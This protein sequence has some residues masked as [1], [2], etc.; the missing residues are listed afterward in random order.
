MCPLARTAHEGGAT[1]PNTNKDVKLDELSKYF[2]LPEKIVAKELGIC[3]T[4]LKKLCRS[5]GITRW[6]FRKLKSLERTMRKVETESQVIHSAG[7]LDGTLGAVR[8]D[9]KAG[10][11]GG[12]G[13]VK[14]RPYTVG[15]KTVFLSDEELEVYKMTMGKD[16]LSL[17]V[18]APLAS[19]QPAL[20]RCV[21]VWVLCESSFVFGCECGC[22]NDDGTRGLVPSTSYSSCLAPSRPYL[23]VYMCVCECVC[24]CI[25]V[26]ERV[27]SCVNVRVRFVCACGCVCVFMCMC[28]NVCLHL[29]CV[30]SCSCFLCLAHFRCAVCLSLV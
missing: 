23:C 8:I 27:C 3:L 18:P 24:E 14:R 16:G 21:C 17:L 29:V 11:W 19:L 6:P 7:A 22:V 13:D 28:A 2:H 10:I 5:Y 12:A 25:C 20:L 15:N 1:R 4:S 30:P 9:A 26:R